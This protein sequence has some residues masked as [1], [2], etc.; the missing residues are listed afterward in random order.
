MVNANLTPLVSVIV[1]SYNH[2]KY[3]E[4]T[5]VSVLN[6]TYKNIQL[7]VIDDGSKDDSVELICRLQQKYNFEFVSQENLGVAA[8]LNRGIKEFA[9]GKYIAVLASDDYWGSD[10]IAEQVAFMEENPQFGM[11]Y[12]RMYM[13][14]HDASE[15]KPLDYI[16]KGLSGRIFNELVKYNFIFPMTVLIHRY[17]FERV[18]YYNEALAVEDYDFFLRV[19]YQLQ[20]GFLDRRSSYYRVHDTNVHRN[21]KKM[22]VH[23]YK[24]VKMWKSNPEVYPKMLARHLI[25]MLHYFA[26]RDQRRSYKFFA[27]ALRRNFIICVKS[28]IFYKGVL[29][30]LLPTKIT[31]YIV[32]ITGGYNG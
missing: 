4:Q 1:P 28:L 32:K 12:S 10:K 8:T 13:V 15:I 6:Q 17:V 23:T 24:I 16:K 11:C 26:T 30:M 22:A 27:L 25:G 5:I 20:I 31:A 7:I 18:G 2:A 21:N 29:R 3:V 19:A 14:N 9:K